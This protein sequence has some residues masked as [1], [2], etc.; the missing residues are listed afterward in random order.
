MHTYIP[1]DIDA[2]NAEIE[3]QLAAPPVPRRA[4]ELDLKVG[5][6]S[7]DALI[8]YLRSF[9]TDLHMGK[10]SNG[11][12]GGYSAG[13]SYSLSIDESITHD[14]WAAANDRYVEYLNQRDGRA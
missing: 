13:S 11:A 12:S 10:I 9:E 5:A 7:L 3:A 14:S 2:I 4:Y 6:D 8:G 1:V